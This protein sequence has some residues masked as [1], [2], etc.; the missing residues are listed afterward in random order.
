MKLIASM[1]A[2][3]ALLVMACGGGDDSA[4]S[5]SGSSGSSGSDAAVV[6]A[7]G[8]AGAVAHAGLPTLAD[9]PSGE[10]AITGQD[11]FGGSDDSFLEAIQGNSDCESLQNLATLENVFG[12]SNQDTPP[13]GQAQVAFENQDPNA[14]IPTSVDVEI[15]VD[16]SAAGS[17]AQFTIVKNLFESDDTSNCLISVLNKQ[18][19]DSGPAGV[20]IEVKKGTSAAG[21]PEDGARMA[22]DVSL[23][24]AGTSIDMGMQMYFWPYGNAT[25]K[26]LFLGTKD[27][28][29]ADLVGTVLQ[30]TDKNLKA[31]AGN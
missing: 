24:F 30:A 29:T 31:A 1:L 25:V 5:S 26:A 6:I 9:L 8:D 22:F 12:G 13:V 17:K 27:T 11:Q 3:M 10:W 18:F 23:S 2:V 19:A 14:L 15:D 20:Q 16:Q 4:S 7:A 28:L 21:A